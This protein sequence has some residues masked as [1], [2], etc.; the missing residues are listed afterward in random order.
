VAVSVYVLVATVKKTTGAGLSPYKIV[1]I[2]SVTVF[3]KTPILAGFPNFK[4]EFP[5][6]E[7]C[8]Q[9]N[10]FDFNRTTLNRNFKFSNH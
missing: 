2:L 10:L 4:D 7:P 6:T 1:H 9:L 3:E 5:G 8:I